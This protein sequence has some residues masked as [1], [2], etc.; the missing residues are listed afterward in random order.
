MALDSKDQERYIKKATLCRVSLCNPE[1][2]DFKK[3]QYEKELQECYRMLE[4]CPN[5]A[6]AHRR[7]NMSVERR[8]S[9]R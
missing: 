2:S 7:I 8:L 5:P 1:L 4:L 6:E 9:G 3:R